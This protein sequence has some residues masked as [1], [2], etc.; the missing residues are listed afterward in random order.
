MD[1]AHL[2]GYASALERAALEPADLRR[3]WSRVDGRKIHRGLDKVDDI[4]TPVALVRKRLSANQ[5][6]SSQDIFLT[7]SLLAEAMLKWCTTT[8]ISLLAADDTPR[9]TRLGR[10]VA[11]ASGTGAWVSALVQATDRLQR[12]PTAGVREFAK[13]IRERK[14]EAQDPN[15]SIVQAAIET[16]RVIDMLGERTFPAIDRRQHGLRDIFSDMVFIRNRTRG[17]GA[18]LPEFFD[19]A[20][21]HFLAAVEYIANSLPTNATWWTSVSDGSV[22]KLSGD[23][24][25]RQAALFSVAEISQGQSL[26]RVADLSAPLAPLSRV[27]VDNDQVKV[28]FANG[29]WNPSSAIC[30][31]I[32]Y[33]S[34]DVYREHVQ[35][36]ADPRLDL[37]ESETSAAATLMWEDAC[38]HN[39]PPAPRD[40]VSRME[41]EDRL[42]ELVTDP[43]HRI[44]T[45][46]GGGGMGKTALTLQVLRNL[47]DYGEDFGFDFVLWFSARDIDLLTHGPKPRKRDIADL[48]A[49]AVEF[50]RLIGEPF[51]STDICQQRFESA[52]SAEDP[53]EPRYLLI[54]DNLET[55]DSSVQIQHFLD[56]NITLPSKA[57][58]TSRHDDFRVTTDCQ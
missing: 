3:C 58:L 27:S 28:T 9:A 44:I 31:F 4:P 15:A 46:H 57:V 42:R 34:G 17:H 16:R 14:R 33:A 51:S 26:V 39:L 23:E 21:P 56:Q 6:P 53:T 19:K 11:S 52:I 47:I 38:A 22:L 36:Y 45:L 13:G 2:N 30:E 1:V 37:P 35:E 5:S 18:R 20:T 7:A 8:T 55:F 48:E 41:L 40:Y 10:E 24:P 12:S 43:R 54:L 25:S 49:M 29:R 32:D 50:T